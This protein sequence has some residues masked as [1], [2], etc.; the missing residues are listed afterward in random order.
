M[1]IH[2]FAFCEIENREI[3]QAKREY[4]NNPPSPTI[5]ALYTPLTTSVLNLEVLWAVPRSGKLAMSYT[6]EEFIVDNSLSI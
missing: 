3:R 1:F 5:N 6:V 4:M 2:I